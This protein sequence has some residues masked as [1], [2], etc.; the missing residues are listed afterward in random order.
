MLSDLGI[1]RD[2]SS[3]WQEVWRDVAIWPLAGTLEPK[4]REFSF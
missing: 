3:Q 1:S 4:I 2:Q